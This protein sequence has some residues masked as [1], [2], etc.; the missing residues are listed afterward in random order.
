[1][2]NLTHAFFGN[3]ELVAEAFQRHCVVAQPA[4]F[5]NGKLACIQRLHSFHD[6]VLP[7]LTIQGSR[8]R[9]VWQCAVANEH[10]LPFCA[11]ALI[12]VID[13]GIQ[14]AVSARHAPFHVFNVT[15]AD[16]EF[17]RDIGARG[18]GHNSAVI[19][20]FGA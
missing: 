6:P 16:A 10:V 3:P 2:L 9:I 11:P 13:C 15:H 14:L 12:A 5:D 1:V 17:V 7:R 20:N 19:V 18:L 4:F 8:G